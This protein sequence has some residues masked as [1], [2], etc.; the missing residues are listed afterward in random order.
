[1]K[2]EHKVH[3]LHYFVLFLILAV[4]FI[5]FLSLRYSPLQQFL[6]IVVVDIL[7][8]LWGILHHYLE[9]RLSWG[10]VTEYLLVG[11]VVL[12]AFGLTLGLR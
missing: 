11:S 10:V 4:G 7:Y 9:E 5:F 3:L 2:T 12:L 6:V 1:M 8:L